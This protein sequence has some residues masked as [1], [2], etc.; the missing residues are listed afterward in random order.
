MEMLWER[1]GILPRNLLLVEV[2]HRKMPY[3]NDGRYQVTVFDR[4]HKHGSIIAV[5]LSFG[6][7]EEPNVEKLLEEMAQHKRSRC[8]PTAINGSCTPRRRTFCRRGGWASSGAC[9]FDCSCSCAWFRNPPITIT[10][11]ATSRAFG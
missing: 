7:M 2:T 3:V 4:D 1:H 10:G 6:F 11:L 5:E 8:R 9:A